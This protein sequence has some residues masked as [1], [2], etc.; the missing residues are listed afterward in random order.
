M[1]PNRRDVVA[2]SVALVAASA[3]ATT[4]QPSAR[5]VAQGGDW[6]AYGAT[7]FANKYSPLDQID[8][9]NAAR[10]SIAWQWDS[11]DADIFAANAQLG[12]AEFQ[13]TPIMV[14]GLL[15][16]STALCQVAAIDPASGRTVW[17]HDP[18]TWKKGAPTSKG[19]QHRG[20]AWWNDGAAGRIFI[21]TGDNRLIALDARGGAPIPEFGANGE[22]DLATVGLQRALDRSRTDL[23]ASTSPP[24]IC[25]DTVIVGQ[26]I[27]DRL[28]VKD[29]PPGC[30]RG[31][32]ART[33]ALKWVFHTVPM[34]GEPG[35]ET[36]ENGSADANGGANIWA[37]MSA[38]E[39]LGLVYL[40]GSCPTDN[41]YGGR[42]PGD[43]LYGNSLIALDA[44]TGRRRWHFQCVHH[45]VWDYDLPCAPNLVDVTVEGR[46]IR[47]VAQATKQGFLFVFDRLTGKPVWPIEERAVPPSE[48]PGE[49][50]SPTQPFPT[51]PAQFEPNGFSEDMLIDSTPEIRAEARAIMDRYVTGPLYTPYGRR[52]TIMRPAWLGGANWHGCGV[53]PETGIIYIPSQSS[54]A[55]LALDDKGE[56]VAGT[57]ETEEIA[58]RSGVVRGPRGLPLMKP[59]YGRIT[60][61]DLNTGAHVWM[62]ANGPGMYDDPAMK[63][64]FSGWVGHNGRTG[65]LVTKTL[66][67]VG[68]GPH[69]PRYGKRVLRAWDKATGD[70]VAEIALPG[71]TLGPPMTYMA[72]GRQF[73]V[74]GMGIGRQPHR[75]VALA[76]A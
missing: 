12:A 23:F 13:A 67:F 30:V 31:F 66:L 73:I 60:A 26:Y 39:E 18:G 54:A 6:P 74:C 68:E 38:D 44:E 59:P 32:D 72:D 9:S 49:R 42:R 8:R 65:P 69:E 76:L 53:D 56:R 25:R 3:C 27:H 70:V 28:V 22:V 10:L 37:P 11:P 34:R 43:N 19:W 5:A 48:I 50:T 71:A 14:G 20:V 55:S 4:I 63:P 75:L 61:I 29:M 46:R 33:G 15:Y 51:R 64:Y 35:Y 7:N 1:Q 16:T 17:R 36:W 57:D 40:P 62:K 2:G 58:G 52:Q 21:A 24:T 47:A 41:F 45:D